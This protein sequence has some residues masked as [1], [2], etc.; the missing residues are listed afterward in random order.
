MIT[1][2]GST[3]AK[4]VCSIILK[5]PSITICCSSSIELNLQAHS[6]LESNSL[7]ILFF[8]FTILIISHQPFFFNKKRQKKS[9]F[10]SRLNFFVWCDDFT[11]WRRHPESN[12]GSEFCRL[13][14]YRLAIAPFKLKLPLSKNM[15]SKVILEREAGLKPVTFALARR[16]S[17]N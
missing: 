8:F 10:Y 6:I 16:R 5:Q 12:R 17:I 1:L 15:N 14:P 13:V 3:Y 2:C 9:T 4:F 11:L 7:L